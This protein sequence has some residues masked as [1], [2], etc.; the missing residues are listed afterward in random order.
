MEIYNDHSLTLRFVDDGVYN[1]IAVARSLFK[2]LEK[3]AGAS[4]FVKEFNK[5]EIELIKGVSK[6]INIE[7]AT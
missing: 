2:K 1:E 5:D 3:K 4:G 7:S 6:T